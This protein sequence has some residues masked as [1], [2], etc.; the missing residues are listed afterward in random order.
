MH[1]F[2]FVAVDSLAS[3]DLRAFHDGDTYNPIDPDSLVTRLTAVGF[4]T[5]AA[6]VGFHDQAHLTRHFRRHVGT[7]LG[8]YRWRSG[9]PAEWRGG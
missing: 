1:A 6:S 7:T 4:A 9:A 5:V 3:D 2:M 8:R